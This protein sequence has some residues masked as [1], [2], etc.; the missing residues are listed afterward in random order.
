MFKVNNKDTRTLNIFHTFL[1][2]F[3]WN[4]F[5]TIFQCF[6][7][8]INA[9]ITLARKF[10]CEFCESFKSTYFVKYFERLFLDQHKVTTENYYPLSKTSLFFELL[11]QSV[12]LVLIP[13]IKSLEKKIVKRSVKVKIISHVEISQKLLANQLCSERTS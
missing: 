4:I 1:W 9:E 8:F 3:Y 11:I 12:N 13:L 7:C 10:S 6:Y 2:C 5:H